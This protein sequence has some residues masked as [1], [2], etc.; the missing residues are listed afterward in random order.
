VFNICDGVGI[1]PD[2]PRGLTVTGG[3]PFFGG[4]GNNYSMHAIAETIRRLRARP[5]TRGLVAANGG[6]LSKYSVGVYSTEPRAFTA[7]DSRPLQAEVDGWAAPA[8]RQDFSGEAAIETYT[9][10][11]AGAQPRAIVVARTPA[12][13]RVVAMS[14]EPGLVADMIEREPLGGK[15]SL[16]LNDQ[17]REIIQGFTPG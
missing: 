3:L 11:Y 6:F 15:V 17:G 9:I 7:F 16:G 1:A 12:N 2:D 8:L 10:D 14:E 5:G 13:E 4:A